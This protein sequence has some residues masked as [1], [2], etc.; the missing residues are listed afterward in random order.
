MQEAGRELEFTEAQIRQLEEALGRYDFKFFAVRSSSPEEDL[1][2]A[3]FAGGY[4][5]ILGVDRE[6]MEN[7]IL[8]AFCSCL[9]PRVFVYKREQGFEI[10][11]FR[12]AVVVQSQVDSEVAGVGFSIFC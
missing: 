11:D 4:E 9:H 6:N 1:E 10:N 7:A 8:Y 3:S 12:I 5:T 2:G